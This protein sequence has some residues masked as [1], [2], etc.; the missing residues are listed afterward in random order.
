MNKIRKSVISFILILALMLPFCGC[1]R[2][3]VTNS[4]VER[5]NSGNE[6]ENITKEDSSDAETKK[7]GTENTDSEESAETESENI[8]E[9]IGEESG[10]ESGEN[11][12]S[13]AENETASQI[14]TTEPVTSPS[15]KTEESTTSA[16]TVQT[17]Q[18]SDKETVTYFYTEIRG[19]SNITEADILKV[20]S[21]INSII[22]SDMS[23][24]QKIKAVHDWMVKNTTYT[25]DYYSRS[26]ADNHLYNFLNNKIGVC[27]GYAVTFYVFMGEL[28]IPCT[29]LIGDADNG[30]GNEG[31]AWNAVKLDDGY[32]YFMDVTWDDPIVNGTSNYSDG[33]NMSYTY[34]LCPS[35]V[36]DKTHVATASVRT[37]PAPAGTSTIYNEMAYKLSGY[38]DVYRIS[39]YDDISAEMVTATQSGTYVILIEDDSLDGQTIFNKACEYLRTLGKSFPISGK[40]GDS[41]VIITVEYD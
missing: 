24:V 21:I 4:S 18:A 5:E 22:T 3:I 11:K 29:L 6:T 27:Q 38:L 13:Q 32:W 7:A 36:I 33:Y 10:E 40:L 2:Q 28:G 17:S 16:A 34:F 20:R 8:K 35:S 30:D 26:D 1:T 19:Y 23:D 39:S 12:T 31:H 41:E 25:P 15:K 9:S 37:E 14:T